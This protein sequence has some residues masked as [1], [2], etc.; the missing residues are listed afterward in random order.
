MRKHAQHA[1]RHGQVRGPLRK[2]VQLLMEG[3]DAGIFSKDKHLLECGH[4]VWST[5]AALKAR[6]PFCKQENQEPTQ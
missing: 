2:I 1:H 3:N 5:R 6:C 4:E